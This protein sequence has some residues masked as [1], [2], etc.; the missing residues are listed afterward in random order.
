MWCVEDCPSAV[1]KLAAGITL[2]I[3]NCPVVSS[4][5]IMTDTNTC[6][7][8]WCMRKEAWVLS[9]AKRLVSKIHELF[10]VTTEVIANMFLSD[11]GDEKPGRTLFVLACY[12]Q[13]RSMSNSVVSFSKLFWVSWLCIRSCLGLT[14]SSENVMTLSNFTLTLYCLTRLYSVV[15]LFFMFFYINHLSI[16][17]APILKLQHTTLNPITTGSLVGFC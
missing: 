5:S 2:M 11:T 6:L 3:F 8:E 1:W 15:S 9:Q 16:A 14:L 17:A 4:F 13:R 12:L 10:F 7:I